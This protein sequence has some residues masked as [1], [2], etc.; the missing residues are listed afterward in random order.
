MAEMDEAVRKAHRTIAVLSPAYLR[1]AYCRA[2]WQ[3]IFTWTAVAAVYSVLN[4]LIHD[5]SDP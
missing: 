3:N 2:E 1:S 4:D 5:S